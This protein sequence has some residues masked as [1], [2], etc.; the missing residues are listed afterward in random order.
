MC[1]GGPNS[2]EMQRTQDLHVHRPLPALLPLT[3]ACSERQ[4][5]PCRFQD[6]SDKQLF[7][8]HIKNRIS[9]RGSEFYLFPGRTIR[10]ANHVASPVS[11]HVPM[12]SYGHAQ[13]VSLYVGVDGLHHLS[14]SVGTIEDE[15]FSVL[16]VCPTPVSP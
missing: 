5:C 8:A 16:G 13:D 11:L 1:G 3:E 14:S 12:G 15:I 4:S 9:R 2:S 7:S 10:R 6:Q